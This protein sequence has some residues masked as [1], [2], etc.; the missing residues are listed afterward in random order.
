MKDFD[1]LNFEPG[2]MSKN[3]VLS[4]QLKKHTEISKIENFGGK[5]YKKYFRL[6]CGRLCQPFVCVIQ[7]IIVKNSQTSQDYILYSSP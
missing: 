3:F 4:L 6:Q 2:N 5:I 7:I 1:R